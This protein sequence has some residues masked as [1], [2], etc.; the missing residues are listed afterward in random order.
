MAH[1]YS[2]ATILKRGLYILLIDWERESTSSQINLFKKHYGST[3]DVLADMWHDLTT[4]TLP[5]VVLNKKER[6]GWGLEFFLRAHYFLFTYPR[7]TE[8][9]AK[10]FNIGLSYA[11]GKPLW[12]WI[13]RIAMLKQIKITWDERLNEPH[14][15]QYVISVDGTDMKINE[16]QHDNEPVNKAYYSHK[17]NHGAVK[18][19]IA[20]SIFEP[21]CVW[22]NGPHP[23]GKHDLTI[24]RE[25]G[26]LDKVAL[27]DLVI[28]DRGYRTSVP[29]EQRKLSLP[30]R[31]G[32]P[33]VERLKARARSQQESFNGRI[34]NFKVL[35]ETYRHDVV[36]KHKLAFEAVV[37]TVQYQMDNGMPIFDV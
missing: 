10:R 32:N 17:I 36:T 3:H 16:V 24:L 12:I 33:E 8:Q 13:E 23:G 31:L 2:P 27:G 34:K 5:G 18:Y 15:V 21:R 1:A 30:N 35:Y 11:Q 4:I 37:V 7:N 26:L 29:H 22:V 9:F 20:L 28:A 19:E 25:G 14:P 6:S